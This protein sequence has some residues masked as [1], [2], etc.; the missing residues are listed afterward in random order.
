MADVLR[1]REDIEA[2]QHLL[3]Y[4]LQFVS[5]VYSQCVVELLRDF[6]DGSVVA[7]PVHVVGRREHS[8]HVPEKKNCRGQ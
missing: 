1:F 2:M 8:D 3:T 7:G 5:Y 4:V 6:H